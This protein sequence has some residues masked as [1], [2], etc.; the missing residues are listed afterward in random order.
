MGVGLQR[1]A[2][3]SGLCPHQNKATEDDVECY[4]KK[5]ETFRVK[6]CMTNKRDTNQDTE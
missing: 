2:E 6:I 4:G 3:E 5:T 1:F